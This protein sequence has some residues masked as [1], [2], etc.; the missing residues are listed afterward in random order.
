LT[1][2][3]TAA[4]TCAAQTDARFRILVTGDTTMRF[5]NPSSPAGLVT[6]FGHA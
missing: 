1:F 3:C 4:G 5:I 6:H 2:V